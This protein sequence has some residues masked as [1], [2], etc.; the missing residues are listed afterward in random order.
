M[1]DKTQ[2]LEAETER[3]SDRNWELLAVRRATRPRPPTA[4][5]RASSPSSAT[6]SA[7]RSTAFSA[8]PI[9]CSTRRSRPS[10]RTYAKAAKTSG[11]TLLSLIEEILDFSK[12]EAGKLDLEARPFALAALV[13]ETVELLAPRAQAKGIEIAVF[14]DERLPAH[15]RRRRRAPAPGAAQSRRQRDQVHRTRRRR[16]HRRAGRASRRRSASL[17]RDTGIGI[18]PR[19]RRASSATSSR[20]TAPRRASSAAPGLGLAISKRIVE[21]MGGR[22]GVESEPGA[23]RDLHV[24]ACRCRRARRRQRTEF[25][26]PDLTGAAVMIVAPAEIEA[27]LLA[28][29]LGRWGARI[30]TAPDETHRRRV[31][32]GTALGCACWSTSARRRR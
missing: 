28:R 26:A 12:I 19:T 2:R 17:V 24:H 6:R 5:S 8:W 16:R 22:I 30:C 13:E 3:L 21:R 11:E 18:A 25:A 7:R 31:A 9:C 1:V 14:V 10:R 4:P 23:R 20:P 29:R 15:G 27:S 32:A